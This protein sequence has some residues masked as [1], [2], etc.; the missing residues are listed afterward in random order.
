MTRRILVLQL[1]RMGD[2]LQTGP[3]LRG[4]R[5]EWP[6]ADITLVVADVFASTPLPPRLFDRLVVFPYTALATGLVGPD[7]DWRAQLQRLE[8][9]V[10][11]LGDAYDL[12]VN[13][14]HSDLSS[15]LMAI[16]PA[17]LKRGSVITP[18]R[19]T[20]VLGAWMQ[21]VWANA[22]SRSLA[23]FNLVDL[24]TWAAGVSCDRE[25]LEI[26]V[27]ESAQGVAAGWLAS[28]GLSGV[29]ILALQLGASEEG[30]RWPAER[31]AA[32]ADLLPP[33]S[34][35]ILLVGTESERPL[36]ARFKAV[37]RRSVHDAVGATT[38]EQL[39]AL[40]GRCR[41][42]ITN[43][44]GTMHVA[45]AVGTRVMAI[46]TGP[47]FVHETGP[48][49][50]G[51]LVVEPAID[52]FPCATQSDCHHYACHSRLAP[53]DAAAIARFALGEGPAPVVQGVRLLQ[54]AWAPSGRI[55]YRPISPLDVRPEDVIRHLS[56]MVWEQTLAVPGRPSLADSD[57]EWVWQTEGDW[58]AIATAL[59]EAAAVASRAAA[60]ARS[61]PGT[62]PHRQVKLADDIHRLL[63]RLAVLRETE[64]SC[65]PLVAFLSIEI[66]SVL[67]HDL[68]S[69]ARAQAAAYEGAADRAR[70][71]AARLRHLPCK[72]RGDMRVVR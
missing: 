23:C 48:Y 29:P 46:S 60:M 37:A 12:A 70:S 26:A 18:D 13:V 45:T 28:E 43:D 19:R 9:F 38:V 6:D 20:A 61:L 27:S 55:Q 65:H 8:A 72:S 64:R 39:A 58:P 31:F 50:T 21:Y 40:L 63:Q 1:S 25:G 57:G 42:L 32:M 7:A 11:D 16:L 56:A 47:V 69:V 15:Y 10:A 22:K 49:G 30:K 35:A 67:P 24:Y 17:R 4:L 51:H 41:L 44:T 5:R 68:P 66:D 52:C 53:A 14:T 33:E 54:A 59:D 62:P 34:G 3:M 36:A 2:L 71:L